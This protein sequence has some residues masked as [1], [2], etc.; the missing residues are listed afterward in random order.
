MENTNLSEPNARIDKLTPNFDGNHTELLF[1][2]IH[3]PTIKDQIVN[4]FIAR[5]LDML[6]KIHRGDYVPVGKDLYRDVISGNFVGRVEVGSFRPRSC[7]EITQEL[8]D[9]IKTAESSTSIS[10]NSKAPNKGAISLNWRLPNGNKPNIGQMSNIEAHEKGHVIRPYHGYFFDKYFNVGFDK[11]RIIFTR[12][13][14]EE[15]MKREG[16]GELEEIK[17]KSWIKEAQDERT[18]MELFDKPKEY[19]PYYTFERIRD[20]LIDALFNGVELAERMSQLK[21]YFGMDGDQLFTKEQMHYAKEHYIK[22][23]GMDNHMRF[24]FQAITPETEEA[25]LQIINTS[26]I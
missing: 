11:S 14:Y 16:Y 5:D 3:N 15:V 17:R 20:N 18:A 7:E 13:D 1:K 22:D 2:R 6:G 25:F 10:H 8:D 4:M 23:T 21:N 19:K 12:Q 9:N 24:F 26:G